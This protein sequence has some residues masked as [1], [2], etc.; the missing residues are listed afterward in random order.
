M[1]TAAKVSHI[2]I[3]DS[4]GDTRVVVRTSDSGAVFSLLAG[5]LGARHIQ[6]KEV[7][8][9]AVF[10]LLTGVS[11]HGAGDGAQPVEAEGVTA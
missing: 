5:P 11:I 3:H 6:I 10:R 4:G 1:R 2:E 8:L 7:G 9:E